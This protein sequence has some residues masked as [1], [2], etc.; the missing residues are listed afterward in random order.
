LHSTNPVTGDEEE[1]QRQQDLC[2]NFNP[3]PFWRAHHKDL[4]TIAFIARAPELAGIATTDALEVK[5][6]SPS[7]ASSET[8]SKTSKFSSIDRKA[9]EQE[10]LA[11]FGKRKRDA[12]PSPQQAKA[13]KPC[14]PTLELFNFREGQSDAWQLGESVEDFIKRLPPYTTSM[15]TY[16]W[17]WAENPYRNPRDKSAS[18]QIDYFT[19]RGMELLEESLQKRHDIQAEGAHGPRGMVTRLLNQESKALQQRIASLASETHVLSGKVNRI[20]QEIL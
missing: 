20:A 2:E 15:S 8:A 11:R 13:Q 16:P 9:M 4:N 18:P 7:K 10:R 6:A 1:Q 14:P 5:K 17:I 3:K 19:S 12:S